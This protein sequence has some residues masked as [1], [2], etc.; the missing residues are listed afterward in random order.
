MT[1]VRE[2]R[3]IFS[4][5]A[6]FGFLA[7]NRVWAFGSEKP[8]GA[9]AGV[10][11]SS[12]SRWDCGWDYDGTT[13]GRLVQRYY[14]STYGRFSTPD[15][16]MDNVDY[17]S[18]GSWNAYTYS[19]GDPINLFDPTGLE[20]CGDIAVV[21]TSD[22]VAQEVNANTAQGHFIDLVWNE[23]GTLSQTGGNVGA[24]TSEFELIA[25]A[26]WDRYQLVS[27]NVAVTSLNG[28]VYSAAAGN[29]SQLGYGSYG[30]S[31]NQVLINAAAG[32][33]EL[34]SQGQLVQNASQLQS[35]LNQN[36]TFQYAPG[37]VALT[38]LTG[39]SLW[40]TQGCY[41]VV[42]AMESANTVADGGNFNPSGV[43]VTSWNSSAPVNNPNYNAGVEQLLGNE[44]PTNFYGFTGFA[45]GN[46]EPRR[47]PPPTHGRRGG[48]VRPQ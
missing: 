47:P 31:L 44:G 7:E 41:S 36:Q 30:S 48:P 11:L 42:A 37:D 16:S 9:G 2:E 45:Y 4:L 6:G 21:G 18:S 26:V 20:A 3:E 13:S 19:N 39:G 27:G 12:T 23:A 40:V 15:P 5:A 46:Y 38:T 22:T 32:T 17:S 35:D 29:V 1:S 14:A 25:Q 24:W 10:W 8:E 34:N 33:N 28:T 43:F